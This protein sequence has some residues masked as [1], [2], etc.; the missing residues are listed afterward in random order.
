MEKIKL[1]YFVILIG[2]VMNVSLVAN[3]MDKA[4]AGS[5]IEQA[6]REGKQ[7]ESA[8]E[9]LKR[10]TKKLDT[11][12]AASIISRAKK[13]GRKYER[14]I[15]QLKQ[16]ISDEKSEWQEVVNQSQA[17]AKKF[18][19]KFFSKKNDHYLQETFAG[20]SDLPTA[21][22]MNKA[23]SG[24]YI[25]VSF[26]LPKELLS[27]LDSI[28]RKIG[29]RLVMRGV[30]GNSFKEVIRFIVE[31]FNKRGLVIDIHP[32]LFKQFEIK[33][34]PSF[35]MWDKKSNSIDKMVGNVTIPYVLKEFQHKG[36]TRD[37]SAKYINLLRGN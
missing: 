17:N 25:F 28:A 12:V 35:V 37:L 1:L 11:S 26:S 19:K 16:K 5:V 23:K 15:E 20:Y 2:L 8:I 14:G 13:E 22:D 31:K 9:Y 21:R 6:K 7:Y 32:K 27:D 30:K 33:H 10:N 34:V 36:D 4:I 24:F 29:A 18:V 3:G